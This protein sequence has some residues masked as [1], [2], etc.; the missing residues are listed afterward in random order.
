[1]REKIHIVEVGLRD[2]LQNESVNLSAPTRLA[3]TNRLVD[4]GC[5]RIE[6]GS[7]VSPKWVPQMSVSPSLFK[8]VFKL[9]ETE[10]ISSEVIF[11]A[12]VPNKRGMQ[13]AFLHGVK[14]VAVFASC[15]ETFSQKNI[16]CSIDESYKRFSEVVQLAKKNKIKVR[17]YLSVCFGC[18]YE[19]EVSIKQLLKSVE[20]MLNLGVFEISFGDTIGVAHPEQVKKSIQRISKVMPL[21]KTSMH[22]HNTRGLA[23]ANILRSVDMG[24]RIFDSS[25]G[26]LGGCPYA[27]GATG[28]VATEDVVYMLESMGAKTGLDLDK[29]IK[30]NHWLQKKMNKPLP[31]QISKINTSLRR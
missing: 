23:L 12:L 14:E 2:G 9:Q 22:F 1:M 26:G 8:K 16:N 17:G 5:K 21:K 31:A 10:K 27:K 13:E 3:L 30:I 6:L 19:G 7:F 24:V 4:A 29:L 28:N 15:T 25:I 20:K 18:P 11:S